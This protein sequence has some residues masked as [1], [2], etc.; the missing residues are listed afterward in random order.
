MG[1]TP[2]DGDEVRK[3]GIFNVQLD[4]RRVTCCSTGY[5]I[6]GWD[7]GNGDKD[8][9]TLETQTSETG[10][11]GHGEFQDSDTA[12]NTPHAEN[13]VLRTENDCLKRDLAEARIKLDED[14]RTIRGLEEK[15]RLL[16]LQRQVS[17]ESPDMPREAGNF[18]ERS[19]SGV[20]SIG[21]LTLS[22][23][24][25][26]T[27]S[28]SHDVNPIRTYPD[29]FSDPA[30]PT[31][32]QTDAASTGYAVLRH[33]SVDA[34]N[35][36]SPSGAVYDSASGHANAHFSIEASVE[37]GD[38][39][40]RFVASEVSNTPR[41]PHAS[42]DETPQRQPTPSRGSVPQGSLKRKRVLTGAC[43][44]IE[45]PSKR[46]LLVPDEQEALAQRFASPSPPTQLITPSDTTV[47]RSRKRKRQAKLKKTFKASMKLKKMIELNAM[48]RLSSLIICIMLPLD[49]KNTAETTLK[50]AKKLKAM[51]KPMGMRYLVLQLKRVAVQRRKE[52]ARVKLRHLNVTVH[53]L[54]EGNR[55]R[56]VYP[57]RSGGST[58]SET[59]EEEG[60]IA[61]VYPTTIRKNLNG[62]RA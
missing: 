53:A 55:T 41:H 49:V 19:H 30:T 27:P 15:I 12:H 62:R 24:Q 42:E 22:Q 28:S 20:S 57:T 37:R 33:F 46:Q 32:V 29:Y 60:G 3:S 10:N 14:A 31:P 5:G 13:Q 6:V 51:L 7:F 39:G 17:Q 54:A 1:T 16:E 8:I 23:E 35:L 43:A 59:K 56:S 45:R 48:N 21:A 50:P 40:Q 11:I 47:K 61:E 52:I 25:F 38:T 34:I 9:E 4:E 58:K 44:C 2:S 18:F 36:T 26:Y